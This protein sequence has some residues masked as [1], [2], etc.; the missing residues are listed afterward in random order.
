MK[1]IIPTL[2]IAPLTITSC[3]DNWKWSNSPYTLNNER[4]ERVYLKDHNIKDLYD[5][6]DKF[7]ENTSNIEN[8]I[9]DR[10]GKWSDLLNNAYPLDFKESQTSLISSWDLKEVYSNYKT[11]LSFDFNI[12]SYSAYNDVSGYWGGTTKSEKSFD[13]FEI[14]R[15]NLTDSLYNSSNVILRNLQMTYYPNT[16]NLD[17]SNVSYGDIIVENN[18]EAVLMFKFSWLKDKESINDHFFKT[19][20]K[21]YYIN[22]NG[23]WGFKDLL[24]FNP[25]A[26]NTVSYHFNIQ[27]QIQNGN[28]IEVSESTLLNFYDNV[29]NNGDLN[30]IISKVGSLTQNEDE[31][32]SELERCNL[33]TNNTKEDYNSIVKKHFKSCRGYPISNGENYYA[34]TPVISS[35]VYRNLYNVDT[36]KYVGYL[37]I[38]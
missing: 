36:N 21:T 24:E 38:L 25:D 15:P 34:S 17:Y 13:K 4:P 26:E 35:V 30:G 28:L 2:L 27:K 5:E 22:N 14:N 8:K 19:K 9:T 20:D 10:S 3:W 1:K 32:A 12:D 16:P 31:L 23:P 29:A 18:D 7:R 11:T 6:Y 33:G 37:H